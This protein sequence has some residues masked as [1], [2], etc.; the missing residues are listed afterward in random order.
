MA[1]PQSEFWSAVAEKY[2]RVVDLQIGPQTRS[3]VRQRLA[4]E[5]HFGRVAEFGC[6]TGYYTQELVNHADSV[7]AT[8]LASGMLDVA[9]QRVTATNVKFQVED[10][11]QTSFPNECFDT[12]FISLV[13]HFTDAAKALQE[14]NRI[15]APGGRLIIAN[16]DPGALGAFDRLRC[17]FRI[18]YHGITGYREKPPKGFAKN[19]MTEKQLCEHL[20][21]CGFKVTGAVTVKDSS[22]PSNIPVEYITAVKIE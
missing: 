15:L 10:C 11:Q 18:L 8:D 13:L 4:A 2:D 9:R 7:I 5:G 19:I 3:L 20:V 12:I 21:K 22:R 17:Q 14:M 6:G 16:L 1:N